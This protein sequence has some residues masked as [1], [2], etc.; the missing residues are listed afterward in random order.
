VASTIVTHHTA[1][2]IIANACGPAGPR[3]RSSRSVASRI[4]MTDQSSA[5]A[6]AARSLAFWRFHATRQRAE[7]NRACSRR[8]ANVVPHCSQSRVS[9]TG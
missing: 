9:T 2:L 6:P 5:L 4:A 1:S 7:Q 3:L 8:G